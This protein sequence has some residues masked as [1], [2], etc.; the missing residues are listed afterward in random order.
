M[1][2]LPFFEPLDVMFKDG[3]KFHVEEEE[4]AH[5]HAAEK[6]AATAT[7]AEVHANHY[8]A[9]LHQRKVDNNVSSTAV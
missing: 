4:E 7:G 1:A 5:G 2:T 9:E 6:E 3:E 8:G